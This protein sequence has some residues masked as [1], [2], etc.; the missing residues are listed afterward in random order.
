MLPYPLQRC[1]RYCRTA[2]LQLQFREGA[3][4]L[5][6]VLHPMMGFLNRELEANI[7]R[8]DLLYVLDPLCNIMESDNTRDSLTL[9][10]PNRSRI[11][12]QSGSRSI[13]PLDNI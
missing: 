8:L 6:I 2:I 10:I 7:Q 11:D 1:C 9:L 5:Q 13:T 3:N 4:D 12:E